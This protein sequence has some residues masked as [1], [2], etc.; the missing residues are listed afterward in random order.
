MWLSSGDEH[1]AMLR[2]YRRTQFDLAEQRITILQGNGYKPAEMTVR[3]I[4][5]TSIDFAEKWSIMDCAR[6]KQVACD[7][8]FITD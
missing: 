3:E 5:E 2:I 1:R 8:S 6:I 4:Y 7:N